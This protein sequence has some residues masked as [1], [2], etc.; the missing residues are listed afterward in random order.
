MF[1]IEFDQKGIVSYQ[2][3]HILITGMCKGLTSHNCNSKRQLQILEL[4]MGDFLHLFLLSL[5]AGF[6][7]VHHSPREA[8]HRRRT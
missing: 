4:G 3:S 1:I 2:D 6:Q 5:H 7:E 8:S